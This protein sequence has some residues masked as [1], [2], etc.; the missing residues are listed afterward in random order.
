MRLTVSSPDDG[1]GGIATFY[2][3]LG[4][5]QVDQLEISVVSANPYRRVRMQR[6]AWNT[7]PTTLQI[8][9]TAAEVGF[10]EALSKPID[11]L[12]VCD[13]PLNC[14]PA[15]LQQE[16]PYVVQCHGS[17]GQIAEHDPQTGSQMLETLVQ[18]IEPQLLRSAHRL[19]TYSRSN[20]E[21]W[22]RKTGRSVTLIR[23]AF[24]A[25]PLPK[26]STLS[27]V[28][29]AFGRL[30]R[31]KGPH[32]LCEALEHL[33]LSAPCVEWYGGVK[34]WGD[35]E[36]LADRRLAED[37]PEIWGSRFV[38]K[39]ALPRH[40]VFALQASALFNVVPS[41][42]D[43][44][45]FT[46]VEAM[47]AARPTVVSTGA[48]ASEL[49]VDGENGFVFE[50]GDAK[51]LAEVI[52]RIL[53]MPEAQRREIGRAGRETIT[54]ELAPD[55]II[56]QR[57]EAYDEAIRSFHAFPPQKPDDWLMRLLTPCRDGTCNYDALLDPVPLQA[58]GEHMV[59][60]VLY[61]SRR[62]WRS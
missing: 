25:P 7:L 2:A 16:L 6:P 29:R 36:W 33:G 13:W 39:P 30:Q 49:I 10:S 40:D 28:G 4:D 56:Q 44:F 38:H 12:E 15:I 26:D 14:A 22:E 45:N 3:H 11:V 24:K 52:D 31:W 61:K 53:A 20:Q 32:I 51:G 19:Q 58:M 8:M 35:S 60:R 9:L 55:R 59:R 46:A 34:P 1:G 21:F 47:A 5:M 17:M 43:V 62:R 37:Y 42:W 27:S 50:N 54:V 23:P 18:L 41:T 57:I 48:G